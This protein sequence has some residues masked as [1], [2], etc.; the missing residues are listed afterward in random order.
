MDF[1][2][3]ILRI[4]TIYFFLLLTFTVIIK[5]IEEQIIYCKE[6]IVFKFLTEF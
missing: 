4:K 2:L 1:I 3:N 5:I 6:L